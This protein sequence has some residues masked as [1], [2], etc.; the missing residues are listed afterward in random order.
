VIIASNL[1]I[2]KRQT[3]NE[4]E[5]GFHVPTTPY[6]AKELTV[7]IKNVAEV[8]GCLLVDHGDGQSEKG[9]LCTVWDVQKGRLRNIVL[10]CAA[11]KNFIVLARPGV[12]GTY[13][14]LKMV[15]RINLDLFRM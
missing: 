12:K 11:K 7:R 3:E 8:D 1:R 6:E 5:G 4:S 9:R 15:L 2:A 14:F 10:G 13:I